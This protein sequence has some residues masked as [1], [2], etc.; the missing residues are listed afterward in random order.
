MLV[1]MARPM[2]RKGSSFHQFRK[3]IPQDVLD[4]ARGTVLALPIGDEV[5]HSTIGQ[6]AVEITASLR[7]RDPR[8]AKERQSA[9]LSYLDRHWQSLRNGPTPLTHKQTVALAGEAYRALVGAFEDDPGDVDVWAAAVRKNAAVLAQEQEAIEKWFGP[10]V[11]E[12][13]AS[14]GLQTDNNSRKA[15]IDR[16]SLAV[17]KA[18]ARLAQNASGDY[19]PDEIVTR[20]PAFERPKEVTAKP[21]ST[22]TAKQ[23]I[24]GLV[25]GWWREA[26]AAGRSISTYEAYERAG[27]FLSEFLKHDDAHAVTDEDIIRFKE[28]RLDQGISLKSITAGDLSAIR[29][30]FQWGIDNK[31]LTHNPAADIRVAKV[32]T[33]KLRDP[34]FTDE[35]AKI[36]LAHAR[37][38]VKTAGEALHLY[39]ARRWVPWLCAYSGARVGEMAQLRRQDIHKIGDVWVLRITP[40]A[41]T[42]KDREYRDVPL[43]QHLIE[44][45]FPD[46]VQNCKTEYLFMSPKN[47]TAKAT[48]G[49]WR[50]TKNRLVDFVREVVTDPAVQPNHAWRHRFMT[51]GRNADISKDIRFAITGHETRDEGDDY[52]TVSITAKVQALAKYPRYEI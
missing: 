46:F 6:K 2:R 25:E 50:T 31:K 22:G 28:H 49:A 36:I 5:I 47:S 33:K 38:H 41:N 39:N 4:K 27:R 37:A 11:D 23:T 30:L 51:I 32:K 40:E 29:Q 45:G 21:Q 16:V 35:E 12:L 3:R 14:H 17:T 18:S 13:L 15:L 1:Q 44:L 48:R 42:V 10:T 8:E 24:T 20:Y 9:L 19:S 7:T 43:H 34:G 52:G 26:K